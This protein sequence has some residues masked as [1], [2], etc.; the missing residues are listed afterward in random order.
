MLNPISSPICLDH[1]PVARTTYSHSMVC[2][3]T[4]TPVTL[5]F[6]FKIF[7]TGDCSNILTPSFLAAFAN[8][9]VTPIGSA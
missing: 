7:S 6:F 1:I 9:F 3:L 2:P 8:K 4:I 5:P